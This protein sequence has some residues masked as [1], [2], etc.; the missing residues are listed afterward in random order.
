MSGIQLAPSYGPFSLGYV[1]PAD[2]PE[3]D[4]KELKT[5][6]TFMAEHASEYDKVGG[7]R[8]WV[9][10]IKVSS[11]TLA[12]LP[13]E[14]QKQAQSIF[15]NARDG[16]WINRAPLGMVTSSNPQDPGYF[17]PKQNAAFFGYSL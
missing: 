8:T 7:A 12:N 1:A 16:G 11:A 15:Q 17:I 5:L 9:P 10:R 3:F 13:V 14:E 6:R 2:A 4:G